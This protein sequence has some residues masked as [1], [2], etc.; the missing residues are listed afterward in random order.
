MAASRRLRL[1]NDDRVVRTL[2]KA[3]EK[4]IVDGA[5][6]VGP[7]R[8]P[9]ALA[10]FLPRKSHDA[11]TAP[12]FTTKSGAH[13]T[14]FSEQSFRSRQLAQR[15]PANTEQSVHNGSVCSYCI[16]LLSLLS[17]VA[18]LFSRHAVPHPVV[19]GANLRLSL[20]SKGKGIAASAIPYS[21]T[22]PAWL[23]TT[24]DQVTDQICKLARK[25]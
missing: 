9:S 12:R 7:R 3:R 10:N 2:E 19:A 22:P 17:R 20:H 6:G 1:M 14:I 8:I 18:S 5:A 15:F 11:H 24:P 23:K 25:G 16:H 21:R 13:R 4:K